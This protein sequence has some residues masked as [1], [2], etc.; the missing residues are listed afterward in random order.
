MGL[1][2]IV[3]NCCERS[4]QHALMFRS[5]IFNY[6]NRSLGD[7]PM[8]DQLFRGFRNRACTH[9]QNQRLAGSSQ[10]A[11]IRHVITFKFCSRER[12]AAA[13]SAM[14]QRYA[15]VGGASQCR[16]YAWNDLEW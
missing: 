13:K 8:L 14:C 12:D 2:C 15:G 3:R 6:G 5:A 7:D 9:I 10:C 1:D 4:A 16:G 11:P